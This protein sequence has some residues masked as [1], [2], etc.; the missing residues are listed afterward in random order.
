MAEAHQSKSKIV[1]ALYT[2]RRVWGN[3]IGQINKQMLFTLI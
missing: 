1:C 3:T 2:K